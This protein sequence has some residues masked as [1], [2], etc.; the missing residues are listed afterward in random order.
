MSATNPTSRQ[1]LRCRRRLTASVACGRG[2][3]LPRPTPSTAHK[4]QILGTERPLSSGSRST[5][6]TRIRWTGN[7]QGLRGK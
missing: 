4:R 1:P 6:T 2:A 7:V 5:Q 3:S